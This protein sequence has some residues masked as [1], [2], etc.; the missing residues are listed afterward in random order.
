MTEHCS[1]DDP[2]RCRGTTKD[3]Q[4]QY[5]AVEGS[6]YCSYHCGDSRGGAKA[7][8]AKVERYLLDDQQLRG[9]YLRQKDD[10]DYLS[11]KDEIMLLSA[12]LERRLNGIK[13]DADLMMSVG[14]VSQLVQRLE[15]M[16]INL[17]KIQQTLGIVL[18]KDEVR[19]LARS[20]ADILV[21]ELDGVE[22]KE[23]RIDRI[24]QRVFEA[25]EDAGKPD[26]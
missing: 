25:I 11:M 21:D 13:T 8:A 16:K 24:L 3:G 20:M 7:K 10:K 5:P 18:G 26:E 17:M 4:C 22:D 23:E 14:H 9:A 1:P 19:A 2:Q 6:E 12:V 15:S